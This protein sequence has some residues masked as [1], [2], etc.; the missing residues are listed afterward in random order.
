MP[1]ERLSP[2]ALQGKV[3]YYIV[4]AQKKEVKLLSNIIIRDIALRC[5]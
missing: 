5:S 1:K 3:Y 4:G 2:P